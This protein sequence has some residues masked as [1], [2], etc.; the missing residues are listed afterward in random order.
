M[1]AFV[2][3]GT[4]RI[5]LRHTRTSPCCEVHSQ[6]GPNRSQPIVGPG[7]SAK[8]SRLH[9][10]HQRYSEL[11]MMNSLD[12]QHDD[13]LLHDW[14]TMFSSPN[15]CLWVQSP[16]SSGEIFASSGCGPTAVPELR[17]AAMHACSSAPGISSETVKN[18]LPFW[19]TKPERGSPSDRE[20]IVDALQDKRMRGCRL[21]P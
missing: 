12:I 3:T 16:G 4:S 1:V 6:I 9:V 17:L 2:S 10:K 21:V 19:T 14:Q 13:A 20:S 7:G 15:D 5:Q 11:L 8:P 18:F